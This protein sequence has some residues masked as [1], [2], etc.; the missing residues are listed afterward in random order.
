MIIA[1]RVLK[2]KDRK[3]EIEIPVNIHAPEQH[4]GA[5]LCRYEIGWPGGVWTS[6]GHGF[7]ATQAIVLTLQ[8]IGTEIYC[9]DYHKSGQLMLDR[10]GSGYGFPVPHNVRDMLIGDDKTFF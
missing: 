2:L 6:A 7:D 9:S 4:A 1:T 5:W 3:K 10:P 8:K